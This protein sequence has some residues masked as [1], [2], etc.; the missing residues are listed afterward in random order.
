MMF[1]T[2]AP[3]WKSAARGCGLRPVAELVAAKVVVVGSGP[4]GIAAATRAAEAG[5]DVVV[6]DEGSGPGGQIWR[7]RRLE[8]AGE[9]ARRW[10]ERFCK[11]GARLIHGAQVVLALPD[12][13]LVAELSWPFGETLDV[14]AEILILATG[15]CERFL[16]F[17][18]WT[19]PN[20]IGVGAAQALVKSG[21]SFRNRRVVLAGS[22]PLLL[23][24]AATLSR[25]GARVAVVAE[26][27]PSSAIV[28]FALR[29]SLR[30]RK[31]L[32]AAFYRSGFPGARYRT[33]VWVVSARGDDSV[34][35][36]V[37]TDGR[38]LWTEPC[39]SLCCGYGL[40]PNLELPL[41]LGCSVDRGRLAVDELQQT[42]LAGIYG[43]GELTGVGG[44]ELAL[45]EGEIA[46][47]AAAGRAE[48][49]R[50][51]FPRR[52]NLLAFAEDLEKAFVL[53]DE[54]KSLP[55][56]ETLVCRCEDVAFGRLDS[57]WSRRQ[58][59]LYTR[60]GM[61][62]CQ[63]KI[64]GPALEFLFGWEADAVRLPLRPTPLSSLL[65][66][67]RE[68]NSARQEGATAR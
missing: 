60:A 3:A 48:E 13:R 65:S 30:P 26:Q 53:R 62:P 23:P 7:H 1:R 43:A 19:L 58:A 38:R 68:E 2:G 45:V 37:L 40:V 4:A 8:Q 35:E 18:G 32:E 17:P 10:I 44:L 64:C 31:L 28:R 39:D 20:V 66:A 5:A 56:A 52:S 67:G 59:K 51:L 27:A 63:G 42:N 57:A 41:L 47:L 29:L 36:A 15:A 6:L 11:S 55:R 46:G 24:A 54:L 33:G 16:P 9:G 49:A 34:R 14:R 21:F 61:G 22:G 50:R 25:G 12:R